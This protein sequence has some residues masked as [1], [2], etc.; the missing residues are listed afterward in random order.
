MGWPIA[1]DRVYGGDRAM[2]ASPGLLLH[3]ARIELP[4]Y[5]G[6]PPLAIEAPL[7]EPFR[8]LLESLRMT[9]PP[10]FTLPEEMT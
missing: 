10:D 7:P 8:H 9:L 1:G 2:A 5:P 4:F 3:A 6:K